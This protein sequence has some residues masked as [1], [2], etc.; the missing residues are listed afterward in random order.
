MNGGE[1]AEEAAR[2]LIALRGANVG[3]R[4][5]TLP[6]ELRPRSLED[7]IAVQMATLTILGPI[8]GWKVGADN[9]TAEPVAS[10]LPAKGIV[11]SPATLTSCRRAVEAEIG[12]RF[13]RALP[14]RSEPYDADAV[15]AA[16]GDC[17]ATIELVDPRYRD[18]RGHSPFESLADIG[19]H[20]GLV[21][22]E[23]IARWEPNLFASLSVQL[24]IDGTTRRRDTASNPGGIDLLSRLVWLANAR[25]VRAAG[26]LA[27]GTV[28]TTGSWT[29]LELADPGSVVVAR[30]D[31]FPPVEIRFAD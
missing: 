2:Y 3:D 27:A 9:P 5:E 8:G 16:I 4:P 21:I 13:R 14:P 1:K 17:V 10:P 23:P 24:T 29:G 26:G 19:F 18:H 12:F 15:M 22:G 25:V 7:A 11:L 31:E 6:M 28:V 20:G 30:F